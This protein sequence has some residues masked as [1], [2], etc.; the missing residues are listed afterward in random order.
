MENVNELTVT[1]DHGRLGSSG[2]VRE[3]LVT[4]F[5]KVKKIIFM[6]YNQKRDST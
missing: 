4:N 5:P 1:Y 2:P 3:K 6:T